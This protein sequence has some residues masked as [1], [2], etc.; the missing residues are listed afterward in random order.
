MSAALKPWARGPFE[1]IVDAE[2]HRRD[3]KDY[4]RRLALIG[5]DN[6]IEISITVYVNLHPIQRNGVQYDKEDVE[7]WLSNFHKKLGW[8]YDV[9]LASQNRPALVPK[10]HVIWYHRNR[11]GQY[12]GDVLGV[13]DVETLE[14]ARETAFWVFSE[15]FGICRS[16]LEQL[17][18]SE[19]RNRTGKRWEK[20]REIDKLIDREFGVVEIGGGRYYAS[21]VLFAVDPGYYTQ[22]GQDLKSAVEGGGEDE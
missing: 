16:A 14:G 18:D 1:V 2:M 7:R 3:G 22:L 10:E 12:H 21:E 20:S 11:N 4:D 15:L 13:P 8:F 6:A 19:L 17:V 5:F 9:F